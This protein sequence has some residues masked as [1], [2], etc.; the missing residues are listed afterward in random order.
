[1]SALGRDNSG[2]YLLETAVDGSPDVQMYSFSST[3]PGMLTTSGTASTGDPYEPAGALAV[4][5]M[6]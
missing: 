5:L 1:V 3:S 4:A 2:S 6:H